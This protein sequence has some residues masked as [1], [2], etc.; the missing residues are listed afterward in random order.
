MGWFQ[1]LRVLAFC[2]RAVR[3]LE[4]IAESQRTQTQLLQDDWAE[5]HAPKRGGKADISYFDPDAAS[6][7]YEQSLR[8]QGLIP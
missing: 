6:K 3:A 7:R 1:N 8:D 4:S 5:K 2:R